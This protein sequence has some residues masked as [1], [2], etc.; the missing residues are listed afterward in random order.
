MLKE[1]LS[2]EVIIPVIVD[3]LFDGGRT[4]GSYTTSGSVIIPVIVDML[5]DQRELIWNNSK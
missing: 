5:F 2:K 3:M 4:Y 1:Q